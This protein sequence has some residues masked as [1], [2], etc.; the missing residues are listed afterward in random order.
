MAAVL[1]FGGADEL[2][3]D[4]PGVRTAFEQ[5]EVVVGLFGG[6]GVAEL[7]VPL[8]VLGS[9]EHVANIKLWSREGKV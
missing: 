3:C 1:T 8:H 9:G 4:F 5:V 6:G 2:L 7:G